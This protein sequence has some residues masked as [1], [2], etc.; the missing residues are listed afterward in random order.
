MELKGIVENHY[1]KFSPAEFKRRHDLL[2]GLMDHQGIDLAIV[3]SGYSSMF[4][5]TGRWLTGM[6]ESMQS[7]AVFPRHGEPTA[8][9]SLYPHL[10]CAQR[11]SA[12]KDTRWG[13]PNIAQTVV[14]RIKDHG[15][16]KGRIGLIGVHADRNIT[17]P[18]DHYLVFKEQMPQ[19]EIVNITRDV[20][21][22][23]M[24][25]SAEELSFYARGAECTDYT[26]AQLIKAV[27]PG[28]SETSLYARIMCAAWESGGE[29]EF[30]LLGSTSMTSPDMP[31]PWHIPSERVIEEGDIVLNELS[32][33]YGGCSGQLIIPI[34]VGQPT[35]EYV[36]LHRVALE[37]LRRV[38]KV[39]R[40]GATRDD[41]SQAG[42]YITD[43]GFIAQ[44][45]IV[46][47]WPNPPMRPIIPIGIQADSYGKVEQFRLKEN[48]LMMIEPNPATAD[49]KKGLFLGAL[50]V[51][52]ADGGFSLQKHPLD[53][54]VGG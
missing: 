32:V 24:E 27:K 51:V 33:K 5:Q 45:P 53:F 8:W 29:P 11:V 28:A 52:T 49:L 17:L 39:L 13:G 34:S 3:Y 47:G 12:L 38:A 15:L 21:D 43:C 46:H 42:S 54:A 10:I 36:E 35:A 23:G 50:H 7:Y 20:E 16:E 25:R 19:A 41:I 26:M 30:A 9:N 48:M 44:A 1:R 22:L 31:Y 4:Q 14:N 40:P 6:R 37:T 2:F 18:M